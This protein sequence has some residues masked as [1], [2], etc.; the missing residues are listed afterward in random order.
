MQIHGLQ[1][2]QA[3]QPINRPNQAKPAG[4]VE[5][6]PAV[7]STS[8]DQLD[9]SPEAQQLSQAQA[10]AA[11]E[12]G[13]RADKVASIREAIASGEYE[14]SEKLSAALDKMLDTFA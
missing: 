1:S 2:A 6:P 14:T 4:P 13:I 7:N 5:S 8:T 9:L 11:S 10:S 12:P 3:A